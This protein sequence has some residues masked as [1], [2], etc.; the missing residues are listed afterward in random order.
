MKLTAT[1]EQEAWRLLLV[2]QSRL[3]EYFSARIKAQHGLSSAQFEALLVLLSAPDQRLTM[4]RLS[5]SLLYSSGSTTNLVARLEQLGY[6]IRRQSAADQRVV[7]V[8]LTSAGTEV[9]QGA[10]DMH[11]ADLE[12]VFTPLVSPD[13]VPQLVAFAKRMLSAPLTP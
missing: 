11:F 2:G 9:I 5:R 13:E 7:E 1:D 4:S 12:R 3:R 6:V 10:R 8:E